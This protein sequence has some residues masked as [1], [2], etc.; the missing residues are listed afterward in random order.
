MMTR[1]AGKKTFI[2]LTGLLI[3]LVAILPLLRSGFYQSD[4]NLN[5]S[6]IIS[7][8]L[9]QSDSSISVTGGN[10]TNR[11]N[12]TDSN[13]T[14]PFAPPSTVA[15]SSGNSKLATYTY[16]DY[17]VQQP[18]LTDFLFSLRDDNGQGQSDSSNNVTGNIETD[19]NNTYTNVVAVSLDNSELTTYTYGGYPVQQPDL[20]DFLFSFPDNISQGQIAG[21]DAVTLNAYPI[22]KMDFDATSITPKIN[23]TGFDEMVV[24]ATSN[25]TTFKGVEFGIRQDLT[26]G[27]IYGY[28]QEPNG[29]DGDVTFLMQMLMLNDGI[30]HHYT[31]TNSGSKVSFKID[32]VE[33]GYLNFPSYNDYSNLTFSVCAVVHR[34]T[35]DWNSD[36]DN[37]MVGNFSLNQL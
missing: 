31:L 26:D 25:I 17:P 36:G 2:A 3:L 20:T 19:S 29:N 37:M 15:V 21:S 1:K 8:A 30:T 18:G 35:N 9:K 33:Y 28:I 4:S 14:H 10:G 11:L 34:F 7:H 24:F 23:A 27:F 12:V 5:I 22:Q 13:S 32:G 16:S 6:M